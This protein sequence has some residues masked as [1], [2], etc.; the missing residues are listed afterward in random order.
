MQLLPEGFV[1]PPLPYLVG[2]VLVSL[3]IVGVLYRQTPRITKQTVVALAPWMTV[4]AGL[5]ALEQATVVPAVLAPFA[6]APTVYLTTFVVV[7]AI[8]AVVGDRQP[9]RFAIDS[10]PGVVLITGTVVAIGVFAVAGIAAVQS[11]PVHVFWPG[12]A[13]VGAAAITGGGWL[14]FRS[15]FPTAIEETGGAGL[16]VVFGHALDGL[17]TAVGL[18]FLGFGEQTPLSQLLIDAGGVGLFVVVKVLLA[19]VIVGLLT[20]YVREEPSEGNLLLAAIAAVGLGPGVHNV[21]LFAI[22]G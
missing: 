5:Y 7:G 20:D 4:G 13:V 19:V 17:S 1:L 16:L 2:I 22:V 18:A 14:L 11:P 9:A 12:V 6:S 21:V 8:V 15:F 10:T 3:V